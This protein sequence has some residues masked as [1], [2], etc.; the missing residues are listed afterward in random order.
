MKTPSK[1]L[2]QIL[3]NTGPSIDEHMLIAIDESTH[4]EKLLQPLQTNNK[5]L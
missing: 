2:K 1:L 5:Q 4:E 3:F